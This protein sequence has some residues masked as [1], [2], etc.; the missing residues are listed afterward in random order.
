MNKYA[1]I[2]TNT[3]FIVWSATANATHSILQATPVFTNTTI[4][5]DRT[6][7]VI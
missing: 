2:S 1:T 3:T 6:V 7:L 4:K 5:L